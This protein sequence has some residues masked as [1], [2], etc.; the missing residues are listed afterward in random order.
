MFRKKEYRRQAD[1]AA[2]RVEWCEKKLN[3]PLHGRGGAVICDDAEGGRG[4]TG[5]GTARFSI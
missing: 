3:G 2:A 5:A 1:E 4:L